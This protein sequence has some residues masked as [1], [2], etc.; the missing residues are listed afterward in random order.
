MNSCFDWKTLICR[1]T[2][3]YSHGINVTSAEKLVGCYCQPNVRIMNMNVQYDYQ[4]AFLDVMSLESA[5]KP[6]LCRNNVQYGLLCCIQCQL[7]HLQCIRKS[8]TSLKQV[9]E[10]NMNINQS[11][12]IK[13]KFIPSWLLDKLKVATSAVDVLWSL[14]WVWHWPNISLYRC[15]MCFL[16]CSLSTVLLFGRCFIIL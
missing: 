9:P 3:N 13:I 4:K 5:C 15:K 12:P 6:A 8:S 10:L 16:A 14:G 11:C 1:V 7:N 2:S